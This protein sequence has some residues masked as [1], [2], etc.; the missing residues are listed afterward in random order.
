MENF[1]QS[2]THQLDDKK[3]VRIPSKLFDQLGAE[4]VITAGV[5]NCLY[6]YTKEY[7]DNVFV[8]K[9]NAL[10]MS[11]QDARYIKRV[12]MSYTFSIE[13]DKHGRFVLPDELAEISHITKNIVTVGMGDHIEIWAQEVYKDYLSGKPVN[14]EGSLDIAKA[15][16]GLEKFNF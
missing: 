14:F 2:F 3:R 10:P 12:F 11:S 15:L 6:I 16:A 1:S 9:L 8:P 7:Y 4:F 5:D 13:T